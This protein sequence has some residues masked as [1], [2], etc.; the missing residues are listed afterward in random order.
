M[1]SRFSLHC[2]TI[3][4]DPAKAAKAET[5]PDNRSAVGGHLDHRSSHHRE[6]LVVLVSEHIHSA[7]LLNITHKLANGVAY[8][9]HA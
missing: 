1:S 7:Q 8:A 4:I 3:L 9:P 2:N 6:S 5:A